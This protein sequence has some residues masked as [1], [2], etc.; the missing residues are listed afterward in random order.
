MEKSKLLKLCGCFLL[1][2]CVLFLGVFIYRSRMNRSTSAQEIASQLKAIEARYLKYKG[3]QIFVTTYNVNKRSP[4]ET[5]QLGDD[6]LT[7]DANSSDIYAIGLQ[8]ADL[9]RDE[10]QSLR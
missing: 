10:S 8:E 3:F 2:V 1:I 5:D 7:M 4:N 9:T 6:W